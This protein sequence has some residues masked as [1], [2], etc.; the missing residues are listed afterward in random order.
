M[1]TMRFKMRSHLRT[2]SVDLDL[3]AGLR[4]HSPHCQKFSPANGSQL[5]LVIGRVPTLNASKFFWA[6][7]VPRWDGLKQTN[8][9][10]IAFCAILLGK[11]GQKV[12]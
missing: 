7:R 2:L 3:H 10:E 8:R 4:L 12:S 9:L 1:R 6:Y 11:V 5:L